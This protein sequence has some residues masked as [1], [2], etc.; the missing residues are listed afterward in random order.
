SFLL[1][2][3]YLIAGLPGALITMA[4]FGAL[5][6]RSTVR[7][8][9]DEGIADG[10]T[11]AVFPLIAFGP[12]IFFF[13]IRIWPEVPAAWMLVEAVRGVRQRRAARWIPALFALVLLKLRFMLVAIVLVFRALVARRRITAKQFAIVALL[14][15]TPLVVAFLV[16]GSATNVHEAY[17]LR[18]PL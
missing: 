9:E 5:L 1:I 15:A 12:P 10:T 11:R 2:P 8:F 4:L 6:A 18:A 3:G 17:E 13:A 14:F 16:S 7:M